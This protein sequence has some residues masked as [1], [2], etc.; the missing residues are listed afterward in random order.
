MNIL[1]FEKQVQAIASLTEGMSIRATER[2]I[3]VHRDTVMRLGVRV[4]H[5]CALLHDRLMNGLNIGRIEIDE[6]WAFIGKKQ[7]RVDLSEIADKGDAYTFLAMDGTHKGIIS[8]LTGKR[9]A[10]NTRAFISDLRQ[11][12][13]NQP[14]ITT[15]GFPHYVE[16]IRVMFGPQVPAVLVR[17]GPTTSVGVLK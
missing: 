16:A 15:D 17:T 4:G 8:H 7:A 12:V 6:L 11:R 10:L 1:P 14:Q 3:D 9:N 2:L 5:G 13:V